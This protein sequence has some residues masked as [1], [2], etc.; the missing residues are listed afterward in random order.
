MDGFMDGT[1]RRIPLLST[2]QTQRPKEAATSNPFGCC[3]PRL[4]VDP[5]AVV[6]DLRLDPPS[7]W[8]PRGPPKKLLGARGCQRFGG[9]SIFLV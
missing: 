1:F 4:P 8:K 5:G 6:Q 7:T 9:G 2:S 3:G